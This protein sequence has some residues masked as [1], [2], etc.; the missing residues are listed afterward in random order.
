MDTLHTV[1][2]GGGHGLSATLRALRLLSDHITAVVTVADDGGSSGRL[3]E[4]FDILPPGDLRM[5]LVALCEGTSASRA[6]RE[7][8][9]HRFTSDGPLGG[10]ALGNLLI[11]ALWD[12]LGDEIAGL[13]MVGQLLR[14]GG[15]V[16]PMAAIPLVIEADVK[17]GDE[18]RTVRGQVRVA[19]APGELTNVHLLPPNPPIHPEVLDAIHRADLIVLGPGSWYTSVLPHLLVPQLAKAIRSSRAQRIIVMNLSQQASETANLT[20]ADH[21]QVLQDHDPELQCD[22]VIADPLAVADPQ[23]L[24]QAAERMNATVLFRQVRSAQAA[25]IHDP[26]RLAGAIRDAVEGSLGDVRYQKQ[27]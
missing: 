12:Y 2:L 17:N 23:R 7:V 24:V 25:D 11:A 16:L 13:D 9:Q 10:H 15:R 14:T 6:W 8:L 26:L 27:Q 20:P 5:A 22:V 19:E 4:E 21:L 1:A 3:R 18:T